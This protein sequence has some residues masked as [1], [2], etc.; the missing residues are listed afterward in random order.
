MKIIE[1]LFLVVIM[2]LLMAA[3]VADADVL[4]EEE[5]RE[6]AEAQTRQAQDLKQDTP[7]PEPT[8][9]PCTIQSPYREDW[10]INLCETFEEET[11]LFVGEGENSS[12]RLEEGKYIISYATKVDKGYTYG[13]VNP[14]ALP[15]A[16]DYVLSVQ[17]QIQSNFKA[18]AWGVFVRST[19]ND[20][21]Y[22]FMVND[23]GEYTL[24]GS[25]SAEGARFLGN[26]ARGKHNAIRWQEENTITA[27]I[28]GPLMDFYVN[29]ELVLQHVAN[30]FDQEYLGIILWGGEGISADFVFDDVLVRKKPVVGISL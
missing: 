10:E 14:I 3:C 30:N 21:T 9:T 27:V 1:K 6:L 26:I 19:A 18:T 24:T 15:K 2:L 12:A 8:P 25:T 20:L 13:K 7:T 17:G 23:R 11:S 29:D 16:R 22:F 28:E 4:T 5:K